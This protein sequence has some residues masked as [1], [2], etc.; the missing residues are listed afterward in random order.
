M[1]DEIKTDDTTPDIDGVLDEI[2]QH[3]EKA[4]RLM[5]RTY[6]QPTTLINQGREL[7]QRLAAL[8]LQLAAEL[9]DTLAFELA[10]A[11]GD[12]DEEGEDGA[13]PLSP[14]SPRSK[15]SRRKRPKPRTKKETSS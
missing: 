14:T 10:L 5:G 4:R 3:H 9:R 11:D 13:D 2:K 6:A 1:T 15:R 8:H 12:D 7:D